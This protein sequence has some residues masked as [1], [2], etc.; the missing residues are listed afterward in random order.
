MSGRKSNK[1]GVITAVLLSGRAIKQKLQLYKKR[2]SIGRGYYSERL[3]LGRKKE[4]WRKF[5]IFLSHLY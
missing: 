2:C 5:F 1:T 3:K 4:T